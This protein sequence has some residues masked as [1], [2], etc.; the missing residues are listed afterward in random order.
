MISYRHIL[1]SLSAA[2]LIFLLSA[3]SCTRITPGHNGAVPISFDLLPLSKTI[4]ESAADMT[5]FAVWG[6]HATADDPTT[7]TQ[8]FDCQLVEF[9][10]FQGWTYEPL[11]FWEENSTY[12]FLALY[13]HNA[14][15]TYAEVSMINDVR[16]MGISGYNAADETDLMFAQDLSHVCGSFE[17]Q[18]PEEVSLEFKHLMTQI[19]FK[20]VRDPATANLTAFKPVITDASLSG[21][22][23][24]RTFSSSKYDPSAPSVSI[25]DCWSIPSEN[26]NDTYSLTLE[27]K[28]IELTGST[29]EVSVFTSARLTYPQQLSEDLI[30]SISYTTRE[31]QTEPFVRSV[32]LNTLSMFWEAGKRYVY[33]FTVTDSDFILFGPPAVNP[34]QEAVGGI[35]II[36]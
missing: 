20:V 19:E 25:I 23:A 24:Y 16:V 36:E 33:T 35:M 28:N 11:R 31:G 14:A 34:W 7:V 3:T 9:I 13:P 6:Y 18:A 8:D 12:D 2:A 15:E 32:P 30:F 17:T 26:A 21:L 1:S 5:E 4:V 22:P 10:D 27:N 29:D